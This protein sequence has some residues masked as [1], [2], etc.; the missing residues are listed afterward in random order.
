FKIITWNN[1][2]TQIYG[3]TGEEAIGKTMEEVSS[4]VY[5]D[6]TKQ[7]ALE[8]LRVHNRWKGNLIL[9]CRDGGEKKLE[10]SVSCIINDLGA[11]IGYVAVNRDISE[12]AKSGEI[13]FT[14]RYLLSSSE[15][16]YL[17]S[18]LE[19]KLIFINEAGK[20]II[21]AAYGFIPEIGDRL[22]DKLPGD[23]RDYIN[24][25]MPSIIEGKIIEY[26]VEVANEMNPK[27]L[28][29]R[30][31]IIKDEGSRTLGVCVIIKDVT[32]RKRLEKTEQER[33][34]VEHEL[35]RHRIKFE[36]F[37]ENTPLPGWITDEEGN[38]QYMN[39]V[40]QKN[41]GIGIE[42]IG[43]NI[44]EIFSKELADNYFSNNKRVIEEDK[45]IETI[46]Q[47][48][49]ADGDVQIL[50][51]YKFPILTFGKK[52]V[53]GW[54]IDVTGQMLLQQEL[55]ENLERY[56]FVN[57]ATSDAIYDWDFASAKIFHGEGF[58]NIFG[59]KEQ[60]VSIKFR[61]QHIHVSEVEKIKNIIFKT[62]RSKENKW[63]LE[64][65]IRDAEGKYHSV[66]DKAFIIRS[67]N[68]VVRVIGAIQDITKQK[69][70]QRK[71]LDQE[72][73]SK[74]KLVK[75]IIETQEKERRQLSVELHDNVNQMLASCKLMLEYAASNQHSSAMMT[76]KSSQSLQL[77]IDEIRRISHD[78]SPSAVE[79][80]GL[81]DA[82]EQMLEKINMVSKT[83]FDFIY[84]DFGIKK[85]LKK[86]DKIAIFRIIQEQVNN[87]L[88][89]A[90]ARKACIQILLSE[91]SVALKFEDDGL[92]FEVSKKKSGL[93]LK[94]IYHRVAYYDGIIDI[95][96]TP[97][98]G[99][100]I[101]I[102]LHLKSKTKNKTPKV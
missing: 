5:I 7:A 73:N 80:I 29:C 59:Y 22:V 53:G 76:E 12:T 1:A 89:H 70:L 41:F 97:G 54:A 93:G 92:G 35:Y 87:I 96:S 14:L 82:I 43:K 63:N 91:H 24:S 83:H 6:A 23:R 18:D 94:N 75:S 36:Q 66:I 98:N 49:S 44:Y 86:E 67:N 32:Q 26:E 33:N 55:S 3:Y 81:T 88:K 95:K 37:M 47:A 69:L 8:E 21:S 42:N 27:W 19:G 79:D 101:K 102:I 16:G 4:Y 85:Q 34:L 58:Q 30:Y 62:L 15:D 61:L 25:K 13:L 28:Y 52:M 60:E 31:S 51:I 71:L 40:Y 100:K 9:K 50:K 48:Y 65:R 74:R 78:L 64:Y 72:K 45:T 99:T 68:K 2:A 20:H 56:S 38:M 46:E 10:A 11:I 17:V 39:P 77:V 90:Q 57:K 84:K